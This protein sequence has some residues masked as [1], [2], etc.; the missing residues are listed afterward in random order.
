MIAVPASRPPTSRSTVATGGGKRKK[1]TSSP[2]AVAAAPAPAAGAAPAMTSSL[3]KALGAFG[4][5]TTQ[6]VDG[7]AEDDELEIDV[8][9]DETPTDEVGT[10]MVEFMDVERSKEVRKKESGNSP[11]AAKKGRGARVLGDDEAVWG[12]SSPMG[13]HCNNDS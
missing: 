10:Q 6:I 9:I 13:P 5:T 4:G 12:G 3:Q 1:T 11:T 8:D 7:W 2:P